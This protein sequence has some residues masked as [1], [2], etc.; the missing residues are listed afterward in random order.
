MGGRFCGVGEMRI[1]AALEQDFV[2]GVDARLF[3]RELDER[4]DVER[5]EVAFVKNNRIAQENRPF[6][7]HL[8][9]WNREDLACAS[10]TI[11]EPAQQH[12]AIERHERQDATSTPFER[13]RL[14]SP[15]TVPG[16]E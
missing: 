4:V 9:L 7:V 14:R 1:D 2:A 12:L 11:V 13:S 6:V 3:Q 5:G 8:R 16:R 10:T 15:G